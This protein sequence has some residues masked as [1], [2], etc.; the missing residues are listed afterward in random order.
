MAV[1]MF[2]GRRW[3]AGALAFALLLISA[4]PLVL[5]FAIALPLTIIPTLFLIFALFFTL[6]PAL[7]LFSLIKSMV[8]YSTKKKIDD[9]IMISCANQK[10]SESLVYIISAPISIRTSSTS[11][12][13]LFIDENLSDSSM[14]LE[15][16][17]KEADIHKEEDGRSFT[18][19]TSSSIL[20]EDVRETLRKIKRAQFEN[21][22]NWKEKVCGWLKEEE[23]E[24][25]R[26]CL[27]KSGRCVC[28]TQ[29]EA[30]NEEWGFVVLGTII[31][32]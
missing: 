31:E 9:G 26:G 21:R 25:V 10:S 27:V 30:V 28:E 17:Y 12:V 7:A 2:S 13:D 3:L 14:E 11:S 4:P 19:D 32:E 8:K 22:A 5:T 23:E 1:T 15:E 18:S 20:D 16:F 24:E 6:L 29:R